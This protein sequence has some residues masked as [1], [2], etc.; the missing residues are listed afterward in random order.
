MATTTS[1]ARKFSRIS[2]AAYGAP[3]SSC[4]PTS[5]GLEA[6]LA[7]RRRAREWARM[8]RL[9]SGR[10]GE[11]R[12]LNG[13]RPDHWGRQ[14]SAVDGFSL[15]RAHC[16]RLP[17]SAKPPHS[18]ATRGS[19]L[20]CL[21]PSG[22]RKGDSADV[23]PTSASRQTA[24]VAR[25]PGLSNVGTLGQGNAKLPSARVSA[26]SLRAYANEK[27]A[28]KDRLTSRCCGRGSG[29]G[30]RVGVCRLTIAEGADGGE[31]DCRSAPNWDPTSGRPQ[32]SDIPQE[33]SFR[34]GSR[35]VQTG[36]PN[37]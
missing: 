17:S 4:A 5:S 16:R 36:T 20:S 37:S 35:S 25:I 13:Q 28:P 7:A 3:M 26:K 11:W 27:A 14:S 12:R 1:G 29:G 8:G 32:R 34:V 33:I 9:R 18:H 22:L 24:P 30:S 19:P 2:R 6:G 10:C 31:A 23:L 21:P 15:K